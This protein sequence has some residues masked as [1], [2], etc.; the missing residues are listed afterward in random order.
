M[1][2]LIALI[3]AAMSGVVMW[4]YI[5]EIENLETKSQKVISYILFAVGGPLILIT[6]W[7]TTQLEMQG[8]VFDDD[9]D[10]WE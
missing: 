10:E 1:I 4:P 2:V 9:D 6:G 3:W 7:I 8:I 5:N